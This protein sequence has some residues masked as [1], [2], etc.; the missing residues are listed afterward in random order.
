[1][2]ELLEKRLGLQN[3]EDLIYPIEPATFEEIHW[4]QKTLLVQREDS[5]YYKSLFS[6]D[7]V[8]E[9]LDLHRPKG[10]SIRVVK[11]QEP[12]PSKKYENQDGS[13]NLNQLYASYADGYTIVI[14]EIERFWKPLRNLCQNIQGSFSH[15]TVANMYLTPK[16]QKALMPHY[17]THDVYVLQIHGKKH[18]KLYDADYQTPILNSFQPIFQREQLKNEKEITLHAGDLMYIPRGIPHEAVTTD[19][20]SLHLTIGVYPTQW[21]DVLM[22][23]VYH[24]AHTN[25]ELRK[26]LPLGFMSSKENTENF[27]SELAFKLKQL[28]ETV[29]Q[30]ADAQASLQFIAEEFRTKQKPM[31]DGHFAHLD[32]LGQ[33]DLETTLVH[34]KNMN[35]KVQSIGTIS[36][37]IYPGNVI[38]GPVHIAPCL[39]FIAEHKN[40]FQISE[41]PLL[42]DANK[43]KLSKRLVRGG[44]LKVADT[45][46]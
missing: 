41:I 7:K 16:N 45:T 24:L 5:G 42:N 12:L 35:C 36:R 13:L 1:M 43:I 30:K 25:L 4:E 22:K 38:K 17:D 10:N 44:L 40:G 32:E 23:S 3:F 27:T 11:N 2:S 19:E 33:L 21:M 14:N 39:D 26:A 6:N 18:W 31:G 29:T 34:R 20:S 9:I 28:L 15:K 8:D 46:V 37:I